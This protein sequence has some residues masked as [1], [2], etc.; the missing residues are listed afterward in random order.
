MGDVIAGAILTVAVAI[1]GCLMG[2][3][4]KVG[5]E[6]RSAE[7]VID[8]FAHSDGGVYYYVTFSVEGKEMTVE[9]IPYSHSSPK[10]LHSGDKVSI[11]YYFTKAGVLWVMIREDGLISCEEAGR[12][13]SKVMWLL[14]ALLFLVT[15]IMLIQSLR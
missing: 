10:S 2:R 8:R 15:V 4:R 3:K 14:A 1:L 9:S 11:N 13:M 6:L 7:G 5:Q 12:G